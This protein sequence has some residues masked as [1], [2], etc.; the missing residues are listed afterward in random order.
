MIF[1][2]ACQ[3]ALLEAGQL[4]P[5]VNQLA[6]PYFLTPVGAGNRERRLFPPSI[7]MK[8]L[9]NLDPTV[10]ATKFDYAVIPVLPFDRAI[11]IASK[12]TSY[13]GQS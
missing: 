2:A 9:G 3:F 6:T 1:R 4:Q 10:G 13:S 11:L 5:S 12:P 7:T 8:H